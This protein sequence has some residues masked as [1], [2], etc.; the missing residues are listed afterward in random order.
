MK[1]GKRWSLV[2]IIGLGMIHAGASA[3]MPSVGVSGPNGEV[4][5]YERR[6]DGIH[7]RVCENKMF[8][9]REFESEI[10]AGCK[11]AAGTAEV[12]LSEKDFRDSVK[13][14]LSQI[15][16][17]RLSSEHAALLEKSLTDLPNLD[18]MQK[19]LLELQAQLKKLEEL[20][21]ENIQTYDLAQETGSARWMH[22]LKRQTTLSAA[23]A[24][25]SKIPSGTQ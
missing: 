1:H 15:D 8:T 13:T 23:A 12:I 24:T 25:G 10:E 3:K 6:A 5:V 18:A 7:I 11:L 17:S 2:P 22:Q 14:R 4:I 16:Q 19:E 21:V 20:K 9:Q